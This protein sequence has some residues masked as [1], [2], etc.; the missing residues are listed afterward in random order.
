MSLISFYTMVCLAQKNIEEAITSKG[1]ILLK[2]KRG[3][4]GIDGYISQNFE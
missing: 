1:I 4:T 2:A 3:C